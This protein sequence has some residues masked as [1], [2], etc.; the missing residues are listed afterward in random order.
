MGIEYIREWFQFA[1]RNLG[2]AVHLEA[3]YHPKPLEDICFNCHQ[4]AEKYLKGCL[5]YLSS[6]M[7]PRT[8]NLMGLCALCAAY[9]NRFDDLA[10]ICSSLNSYGIL[11]KYPQEIYIDEGLMKK[12]IAHAAEIKSFPPLLELRERMEQE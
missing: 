4:A 3:L 6:A 7:P 8:H 2:I 1:D 5:L 11:P 12:A 9:D 10:K